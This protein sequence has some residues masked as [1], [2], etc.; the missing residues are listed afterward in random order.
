MASLCTWGL[1]SAGWAPATW[2]QRVQGH[3]DAK[4]VILLAKNIVLGTSCSN[5]LQWTAGYP[6]LHSFSLFQLANDSIMGLLSAPSAH[7]LAPFPIPAGSFLDSL[8]I[9]PAA[10]DFIRAPNFT[11]HIS[12]LWSLFFCH[13]GQYRLQ[14]ILQLLQ[15]RRID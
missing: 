13:S 2:A 14:Y 4:N 15:R 10:S 11:S 1:R 9:I 5:L 7:L 12:S 3:T 6:T 8:P